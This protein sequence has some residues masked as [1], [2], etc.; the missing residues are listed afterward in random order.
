V[1]SHAI[2][3]L[4]WRGHIRIWTK[5][6]PANCPGDSQIAGRPSPSLWW[7]CHRRSNIVLVSCHCHSLPLLR[8]YPSCTDFAISYLQFAVVRSRIGG[9]GCGEC[10]SV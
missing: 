5:Y 3:W 1:T 9:R 6:R 7:V 2:S 8:E 10:P 4:S